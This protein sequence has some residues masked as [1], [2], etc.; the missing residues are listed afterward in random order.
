M[1][2]YGHIDNR[3]GA[4]KLTR[5]T[6]SLG[7]AILLCFSLFSL[8][9]CSYDTNSP[10]SNSSVAADGNSGVTNPYASKEAA[11]AALQQVTIAPSDNAP[12]DRKS[13]YGSGFGTVYGS[14]SVRDAVLAKTA[15]NA[16]NDGSKF[17]SGTW[18]NAYAGN[19]IVC[20]TANDVAKKIQIDHII[21]LG[22][23]N[24]HGGSSWSQD[25][26]VEYANDYGEST[27][28]TYGT[29]GTDDYANCNVLIAVDSTQNM[30]KSDQGPAEWLPTNKGFWYIYACKWIQIAD[31]YDISVTQADWN[32]LRQIV[33]SS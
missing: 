29:T 6:V 19:D 16:T 32:E 10:D 4:S 22:Y 26:R 14:W 28:G 20:A 3:F 13:M 25:E 5:F 18:Y 33:Q 21:P 31:N 30:Q 9:A 23:V 11:L 15:Q 27:K 12:Y 1:R 17:T 8:P 24:D 2:N 7:V